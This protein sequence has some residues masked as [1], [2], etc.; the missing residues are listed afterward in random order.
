MIYW[1]ALAKI[2]PINN[3]FDPFFNKRVVTIQFGCNKRVSCSRFK[4]T[5]QN[6]GYDT[7]GKALLKTAL[8]RQ[9]HL[10]KDPKVVVTINIRYVCRCEQEEINKHKYHPQCE[11]HKKRETKINSDM[12][13]KQLD[14]YWKKSSKCKV[15]KKRKA[16]PISCTDKIKKQKTLDFYWKKSSK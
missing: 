4:G 12:K 9:N 1:G 8:L 16:A 5:L 7:H 13:Q 3:N 10:Q 11:V 6:Y 2:K 14:M 15:H